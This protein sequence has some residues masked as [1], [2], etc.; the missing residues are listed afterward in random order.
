M[1]C[2]ANSVDSSGVIP[3]PPVL[4]YR[5]GEHYGPHW[6]AFEGDAAASAD[7]ERVA[8][9][10]L[11][12]NTPEE[13]GETAFTSTKPPADWHERH[14]GGP[15]ASPWSACGKSGYAMRA[16]EGDALLFYSLT[17]SGKKDELSM[18]A[19]CPPVRGEK[20]VATKW[21]HTKPVCPP[22]PLST[23]LVPIASN[24]FALF[25]CVV[26]GGMGCVRAICRGAR[27][28]PHDI[29]MFLTRGTQF[30]RAVVVGPIWWSVG[31]SRWH[32]SR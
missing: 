23:H 12:L 29:T 3:P 21:I 24:S 10:V 13:G 5:V 9:V 4:R 15:G 8:T 17:P 26:C 16:V 7:G 2:R 11:Y 19:G 18:H 20:W 1:E 28:T 31:I 32:V 22:L 6:D 30:Q 27:I 14:G 25:A